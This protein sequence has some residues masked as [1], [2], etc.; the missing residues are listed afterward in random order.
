M[1]LTERKIAAA[2]DTNEAMIHYYFDGKDGLLFAL[3]LRYYDEVAAKLNALDEI[4][5]AS[6]TLPM[7]PRLPQP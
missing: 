4:D 7:R 1:P 5:P 3:I 2:A 6:S